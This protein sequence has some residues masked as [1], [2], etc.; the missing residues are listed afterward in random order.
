MSS[1]LCLK[2]DCAKNFGKEYFAAT[3]R[4]LVQKYSGA[5]VSF[6]F[7]ALTGRYHPG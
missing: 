1:G 2:A 7:S 5:Y 4:L 6:I 3:L